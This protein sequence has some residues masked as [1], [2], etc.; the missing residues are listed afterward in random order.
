M[1]FFDF[2]QTDNVSR[3][4]KC[5]NACDSKQTVEHVL[6]HCQNYDKEIKQLKKALN[7]TIN[8]EILFNTK[9]GLVNLIKYLKI[10]KIATR[11][12]LLGET[13]DQSDYWR[14]GDVEK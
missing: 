13:D 2:D 11:Q 7:S 12:W 10:T 3:C 1:H 4:G 8:M 14:W 9:N 6:L 5:I